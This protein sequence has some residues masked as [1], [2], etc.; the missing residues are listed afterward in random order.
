M[1]KT[2]I[3]TDDGGYY[4]S[5]S[6]IPVNDKLYF[7]FNDYTKRMEDEMK[8]NK[9]SLHFGL[10]ASVIAVAEIDGQGKVAKRVL[11]ENKDTDVKIRPKVSKNIGEDEMLVISL[12]GKRSRLGK[13]TF[14]AGKTS[15]VSVD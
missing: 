13:F 9:N 11:I 4:L 1:P 3:S 15:G 2:Q 6:L 12:K 7:V 14:S 8:G 5:Y 10:G